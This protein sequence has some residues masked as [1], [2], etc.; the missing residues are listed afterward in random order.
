M[1]QPGGQDKGCG[2]LGTIIVVIVAVVVAVYTGGAALAAMGTTVGTASTGA[3]VAAGAVGG[4]VGSI[5]SQTVGVAI[6]AQDSFSWKGVALA[7]VGGGV[8]AGLGGLVSSSGNAFVDGAIRGAVG[9]SLTQGIAVATG[10]QQSFSWRSVAASAVSAGVGQGINAA[11]GYNPANGF[12]FGKSLVSGLASSAAGQ[13]VRGGKVNTATLATDVFG[14]VLS[15]SLVTANSSIPGPVSADER[16]RDLGY[17][18]DGP[19]TGPSFADDMATRRLA[20]NPMGLSTSSAA[21][22]A[23]GLYDRN[24]SDVMDDTTDASGRRALT[25]GR[26]GSVLSTLAGGGLNAAQQSAGY[27]QLARYGQLTASS[28][29]AKG[30]PIVQAGQPLYLDLN[31]LTSGDARLGSALIGNESGARAAIAQ[32]ATVRAAQA[33][34]D[35]NVNYGNEGRGSVA[36][37]VVEGGMSQA[38]I[39]SRYFANG[40]GRYSSY[41]ADQQRSGEMLAVTMGGGM[42]MP[43]GISD[44]FVAAGLAN[45]VTATIAEKMADM[46]LSTVRIAS[47]MND[48]PVGAG[49]GGAKKIVNFGP[50]LFNAGAQAV[51]LVSQGYAEIA[52]AAGLVSQDTVRGFRDTSPYQITP[53]ATYNGDAQVGGAFLA[54]IA[55]G[56]GAAKYGGYTLG[57]DSSLGTVGAGRL[58]L[59]LRAPAVLT[60]DVAGLIERGGAHRD[61]QG[62]P[63]YESAHMPADSVSPLT[64]NQGSSIAM[65]VE[66]HRLTASW[67]GTREAR[68]Y[69]Q[70][71]SSLI[72]QGNFRA[73]QELD[74]RDVQ[75]KFGVK[76]D[77]SIR[78][79]LQYMNKAGY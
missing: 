57:I 74:I 31:D 28:F 34:S 47:A 59:T 5:A 65:L 9:S 36:S 41:Q 3:L 26:N 12:N 18:A 7:A 27:G 15:D 49:I 1:A 58:P 32:A 63:G 69:R 24:G 29:D 76:Y 55:L 33:A 48:D 56:Y 40:S 21:S 75:V 54:D 50:E 16:A 51:K 73:A 20:N 13:A 52:G 66:D 70:A 44:P 72:E 43:M 25:V 68:A 64:S 37:S 11:M 19:G 17:F 39:S 10:L 46:T 77:E 23:G 14:N 45:P 79:M 61:V 62:L 4:A 71:Q 67:G 60:E 38:E 35:F 42:G 6:G 22:N 78:Q 2:T 8:G 53:L 30:T